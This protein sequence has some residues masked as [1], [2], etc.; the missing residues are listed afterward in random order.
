MGYCH[1]GSEGWLKLSN[2]QPVNPRSQGVTIVNMVRKEEAAELL[3]SLGAE[4]VVVTSR[5]LWW[6]SKM[7]VMTVVDMKY[8]VD[9]GGGGGGI[10]W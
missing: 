8:A 10:C 1:D 6:R 3:K 4:H 2:D 9:D 7:L 5:C